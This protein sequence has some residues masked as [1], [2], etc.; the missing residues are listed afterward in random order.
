MLERLRDL[1]LTLLKVPPEPEPPEGNPASML[2]FRAGRN[3]YRW[4]MMMWALSH[5]G[6]IGGSLLVY[7]VVGIGVVNGPH[8]LRVVYAVVGMLGAIVLGVAATV[9]FLALRWSYELRWY[10]LSDRSLRIRR[11]VWNLEELTMTFANIQE[12]RV[13]A[14]LIQKALGLADVEVHAAGG[15]GDA[16]HQR[17]RHAAMFQGVDNAGEIRDC[18]VERLRI[19]RDSG[20]G[21]DAAPHAAPDSAISAQAAAQEVLDAAKSLR[22]VFQPPP[23]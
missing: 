20:L 9:T 18:I 4:Q 11:G 8:W 6:V 22:Q 19:Y 7:V 15:G 14:G 5:V 17:V 10:I 2:I 23:G 12:V 3:F 21:S 13:N 16:S 1:V